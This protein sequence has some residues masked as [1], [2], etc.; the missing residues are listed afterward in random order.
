M[1]AKSTIDLLIVIQKYPLHLQIR[2]LADKI[3]KYIG[4]RIVFSKCDIIK[5][6]GLIRIA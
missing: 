3:N 5:N 4:I 2:L 1:L 6:I